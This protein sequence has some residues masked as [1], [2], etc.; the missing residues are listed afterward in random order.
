[1][2][3]ILHRFAEDEASPDEAS[4][5]K[6][7]Q[8]N[9]RMIASASMQYILDTGESSVTYKQL[10]GD[11]FAKIEPVNGEDYTSIVVYD[12]SSS[13]SVIDQDGVVHTYEF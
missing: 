3:I 7:I 4:P 10:E 6:A 12:T 9:L 8:N 11:Y 1:M 2:P 13:I 5:E